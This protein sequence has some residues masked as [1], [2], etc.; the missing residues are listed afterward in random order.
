MQM[1]RPLTPGMGSSAFTEEDIP[2]NYWGTQFGDQL[3][4][5]GPPLSE[6]LDDFVTDYMNN[7]S[8]PWNPLDVP[9][10]S[11]LP[12]SEQDHEQQYQQWWIQS[13]ANSMVVMVF[14][15]WPYGRF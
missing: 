12:L 11:S 4:E 7:G 1:T 14:S 10:F 5:N 2:S 15:T 3:D 8:I 6:Q 9:G 13:W